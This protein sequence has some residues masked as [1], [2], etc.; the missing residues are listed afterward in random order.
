MDHKLFEEL[1]MNRLFHSISKT[2]GKKKS[3][4]Y[5]DMVQWKKT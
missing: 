1:R 3:H 5:F 2:W 4:L